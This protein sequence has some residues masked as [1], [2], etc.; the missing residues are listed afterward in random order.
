VT[1][2]QLS[3]GATVTRA[4]LT[5]T[6][7]DPAKRYS[8]VVQATVAANSGPPSVALPLFTPGLF[9]STAP[10]TQTAPYIY[11]GTSLAL[12]PADSTI[13][14]PD[15]GLGAPL[16]NLPVTQ[17]AFTLAQNSN[18]STSST[19][20]YV[21]SI[22]AASE[23][24]NFG[25]APIRAQLQSDWIAFLQAAETAG[26]VPWGIAAL[27]QAL[28]RSMP[29]TFQET[30][31]YAYGLD[32][33]NGRAD[34]RPGMVL[35]VAIADYVNVGGSQTPPWIDG[36]AGGSVVDYDVA[37][38]LG[39]GG[40]SV[41]FDTFIAQLV[42]AGVLQVTAPLSA[43][44]QQTESGVA[45]AADLFYPAFSQPFYR[46][47]FPSGLTSPSGPGTVLT[48]SSFVL[49][50]APSFTA[51]ASTVNYPT[52]TNAVAFFR[53]RAIVKLCIRVTID[54]IDEV[55]P[56]GTTV[57]NVLERYAQR[58]PGAALGLDGLR[59]ERAGGSVVTDPTA[60]FA[61]GQAFPVRLDWGTAPVYGPAQDALTLPLL[62]GDR[63]TIGA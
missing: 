12:A 44:S 3:V 23:A 39:S 15:I 21:L 42:G 14:L 18:A 56:I 26:A 41:G 47:F 19:F 50:A 61:I 49:A 27:Q 36:Y 11:P 55:V 43:P 59:L 1:V 31:Y 48:P 17:G 45:D 54:G 9:V 57:G 7:A 28:S 10:A 46:L 34:L 53:G 38:Y 2:A 63:L 29:Q 8:A 20:P 22:P 5:P 4:M 40:W 30:L 25:P 35:R 13:Y 51:L 16:H 58:P 33:A 32:L 37:S 62:H 52:S 24:W 60:R 6:I